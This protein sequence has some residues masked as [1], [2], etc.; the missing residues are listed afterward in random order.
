MKLSGC[1]DM[2][3]RSVRVRF[4]G[5]NKFGK[6]PGLQVKFGLGGSHCFVVTPHFTFTSKRL[7]TG[8]SSITNNQNE[9]MAKVGKKLVVACD[10]MSSLIHHLYPH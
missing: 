5:Y 7:P 1:S 10:G 3:G 2:F 6:C 8:K 4:A 9:E